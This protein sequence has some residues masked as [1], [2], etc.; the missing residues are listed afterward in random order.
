MS[1]LLTGGTGK[2]AS[3]IVRLLEA[4]S[5]PYLIASRHAEG[6][7]AVRFDW[8][9]ESTFNNPF[10]KRDDIK[11]VYLL[12]HNTS[13][14]TRFI[15]LSIEKGVRRFVL[16]GDTSTDANAGRG[17][18]LIWK[19]ILD[20]GEG[21]EW[22]VLKPT[23]FTD[24]FLLPA[25]TGSVKTEGKLYSTTGEGRMSY[26]TVEDI[27]AVGYRALTDKEPHNAAH[28]LLGPNAITYTELAEIYSK[29]LNK[30]VEYVAQTAEE[31]LPYLLSQGMDEQRA[32]FWVFL[33]SMSS[34][35][36]VGKTNNVV[37]EVT[38]K[39]AKG[40]EEWVKENVGLWQ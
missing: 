14:I 25:V 19:H 38:G 31:R 11:A 33:E 21:V 7:E 27:G 24:N 35:D 16:L 29:L 13:A 23:W 1:I 15:D 18:G 22:A 4:S 3:H 5:T 9:D 34:K 36:T 10:D 6:P 12:G 28:V 32:K 39:K 40:V 2:T 26:V 8:D 20:K 30:S 37:E 17:S